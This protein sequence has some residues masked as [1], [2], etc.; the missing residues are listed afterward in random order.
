MRQS[1]TE[2]ICSNTTWFSCRTILTKHT[3]YCRFLTSGG[4][5]FGGHFLPY[6]W[7][8]ITSA[9][10]L[11]DSSPHGCSWPADF[12]SR[13][14]SFLGAYQHAYG[15]GAGEELHTMWPLEIY[16]EHWQEN[17]M[18]CGVFVCCAAERIAM[19]EPPTDRQADMQVHRERIALSIERNEFIP[20]SAQLMFK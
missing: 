2:Y 5:Q 12:P 7:R 10:R 13:L 6:V 9:C 17:G 1:W 8:N 3:G 16:E 20:R 19:G 11:F 18:D 4:E 15:H 14:R